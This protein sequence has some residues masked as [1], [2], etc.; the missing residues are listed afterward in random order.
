MPIRL[1]CA[2]TALRRIRVT[3]LHPQDVQVTFKNGTLGAIGT[4]ALYD[5]VVS[6]ES[7]AESDLACFFSLLMYTPKLAVD[8]TPTAKAIAKAARLSSGEVLFPMWNPY[9][10]WVD[11]A[12]GDSKKN[13]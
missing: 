4:T 12:S 11:E 3:S 1:P 9:G 6:V 7:V 10:G 5:E 8:K 2:S 13:Q